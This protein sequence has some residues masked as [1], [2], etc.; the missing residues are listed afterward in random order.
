MPREQVTDDDD[1]ELDED[2]FTGPAPSRPASRNGGDENGTSNGNGAD[3]QAEL[4]RVRAERDALRAER[5]RLRA[6]ASLEAR[7]DEPATVGDVLDATS[8]QTELVRAE[9]Q[10]AFDE[11]GE[12]IADYVADCVERRLLEPLGL[13]EEEDDEDD[14]DE[15]AAKRKQGA[16]KKAGGKATKKS[17]PVMIAAGTQYVGA[18]GYLHVA[19]RDMPLPDGASLDF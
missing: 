8:A 18:D 4:A 3:V 11:H 10:R 1:L 7:R 14:D 2:G 17:G 16:G 9:V 12:E 5:D 6:V 15:V 13:A 19:R